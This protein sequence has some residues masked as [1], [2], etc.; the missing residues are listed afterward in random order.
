MAGMMTRLNGYVYDGHHVAAT[1]LTN[2]LFVELNANNKVA[3]LAAKNTT[4]V[5]RVAEKTTLF[6]LP[7]VRLDVVANNNTT[8]VYFVENEW[9]I[10]DASEYNEA[11]YTLAADKYV[12]MHAPVVGDQLIVSTTDA[13][14]A[15]LTV[16]DYVNANA[17]GG[18]VKQSA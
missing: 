18:I 2:G 7:A 9:D 15:T 6:G 12:R 14:L 13:I 16:G 3:A 5:M 1:T 17:G 8:P 4:L 10:N 11:L